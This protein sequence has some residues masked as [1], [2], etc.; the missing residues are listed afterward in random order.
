[1]RVSQ[2]GHDVPT[3]KLI[4]RYPRII[5]NLKSALRELPQ[6]WIFDNDDLR[7]SFRLVAVIENR[8]VAK[9]HGWVPAWLHPLLPET[10]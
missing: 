7:T 3:E 2:G 4:S 6:V 9:L 10:H 5:E 1:M 8:R